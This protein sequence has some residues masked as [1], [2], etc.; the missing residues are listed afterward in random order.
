M[1][2]ELQK[3]KRISALKDEFN[4][5]FPFLKLEFFIVEHDPMQ[6]SALKAMVKGDH[7]LTELN[8]SF[9]GGT[10]LLK[11]SMPVGTLETMFSDFFGLNVQVFR[12]SGKVWLETSST[13]TMTLEEQNNLGKEKEKAPPA[14]DIS[15]IDY[16]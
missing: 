5:H 6:P 10:L 11:S 13:D 3:S 8:A 1:K 12:K 7:S 4:S 2:L 15:D 9:K 14:D 16:D